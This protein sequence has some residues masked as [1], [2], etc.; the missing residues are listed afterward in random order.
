MEDEPTDQSNDEPMDQS[1]DEPMDQSND[2][3]MDQSNEASEHS[4]TAT[5]TEIPQLYDTLLLE[6]SETPESTSYHV[7]VG[8]QGSKVD[9]AHWTSDGEIGV[10]IESR[11]LYSYHDVYA[12]FRNLGSADS[13]SLGMHGDEQFSLVHGAIGASRAPAMKV[14]TTKDIKFEGDAVFHHPPSFF[15]ASQREKLTLRSY[16]DS[17]KAFDNATD[18]KRVKSDLVPEVPVLSETALGVSG[19]AEPLISYHSQT[20][21][22]LQIESLA[23]QKA[24][25]AF[26]NR[27]TSWRVTVGTDGN[28]YLGYKM[29][30][31][32]GIKALKMDRV[33]SVHFYGDVIFSGNQF[34]T[35]V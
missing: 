20:G 21:V 15:M 8:G 9:G 14:S 5:E 28:L 11:D 34:R 1:N 29:E 10:H 4:Q 31:G 3:P 26:K 23:S 18:T 2:E 16:T 7:R 33:G 27:G 35:Y 13:F 6:E 32:E 24:Y 19:S 17:Q 25:V 30:N 22:E 12:E